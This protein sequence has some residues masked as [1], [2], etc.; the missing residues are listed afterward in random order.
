MIG[1]YSKFKSFLGIF[2][3]LLI[4]PIM[5]NFNNKIMCI[6]NNK[7]MYF[8]K[9]LIV[10]I[11]FFI[12]YVFVFLFTVAAILAFRS[13]PTTNKFKYYKKVSFKSTQLRL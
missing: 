9:L 1:S 7:I 11:L 13:L 4:V 3:K 6:S 5:Y 12:C 2:F 10:L 8:V